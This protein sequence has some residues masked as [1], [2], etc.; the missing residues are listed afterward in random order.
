MPGGDAGRKPSSVPVRGARPCADG[1]SVRSWITIC[2][3]FSLLAGLVLGLA[4]LRPDLRARLVEQIEGPAA[5]E[6][7]LIMVV[8]HRENVAS[9][10]RALGENDVVH[11]DD[12][13]FALARGRIVTARIED[14]SDALNA[15]DW[16]ERPLEIIDPRVHGIGA[17]SLASSA[18][19]PGSVRGLDPRTNP[20]D[21]G[22]SLAELAK[23]PRLTP[24]E[25][26]RALRMLR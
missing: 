15:L 8:G 3:F 24:D 20:G 2:L 14:A 9:L 13:S 21:G 23:K 10:R 5:P 12:R 25:A 26:L 6:P 18:A 19:T 1:T 7:V 11:A 4:A 22:P 16:S 17:A